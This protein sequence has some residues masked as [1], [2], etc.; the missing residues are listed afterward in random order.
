MS[1][2]DED[3]KNVNTAEKFIGFLNEKSIDYLRAIDIIDMTTMVIEITKM[4][5][6]KVVMDRV[7]ECVND[8]ANMV[9]T[10]NSNFDQIT[11][12]RLPSCWDFQ[13]NLLPWEQYE[14]L[15]VETK[16]KVDFS[17]EK[18][19]TLNDK[20]VVNYLQSYFQLLCLVKTL[21]IAKP[22]YTELTNLRMAYN[23]LIY[24]PSLDPKLW[25]KCDQFINPL[26]VRTMDPRSTSRG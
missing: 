2:K 16:I 8:L 7:E 1:F 26:Q 12:E 11:R 5:H 14:K 13:G 18:I 9:A 23:A 21:S 4:I 25:Q 6:R 10:F 17:H 3:A 22:K 15:L 19:T 24:T 20:T